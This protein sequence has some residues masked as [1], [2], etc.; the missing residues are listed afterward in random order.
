MS[1]FNTRYM[2]L[3]EFVRRHSRVAISLLLVFFVVASYGTMSLRLD[4]SFRPLFASGADIAA[5]T[6]EFEAVFGQSS[7]A[8]IIAVLQDNGDDRAKFLRASAHLTGQAQNISGITEVLSITSIQIPQWDRNSASLSFVSPIPEYLLEPGEGEELNYQYEELLDGTRFVNWLVSADGEKLL[9]AGRLDTPLDDLAGRRKIVTEFEA[10]LQR[11]APL[12]MGLYFSGVSVVELAYEKQVL[13]DQWIATVLTSLALMLLLYWTLGNMRLMIVCLAPVTLAIPAALGV[14]GWLGHPVTIINTVI[15][16]IML[17]LGVADAVHMLNAWL[18][19]RSEGRN[20]HAATRQ[21][22]ETTGKACFF[23]TVTTMGGFAALASAELE[24]VGD[25]G[26]SVAVGIFLAWLANQVLLP[27]ILRRFNAGG[28]LAAGLVNQCADNAVTGMLR[29]AVAHHR[30]MLLAGLLFTLGCALAIPALS[31]DQR[32]NEELPATHPI[33]QAQKI[34]EQ[35]FGGFLGPEISIRRVAGGSMIDTDAQ[36]RLTRFV[37]SLK[38]EPDTY[39]AWSIQDL[40]PLQL[41]ASE[42]AQVLSSLRSSPDTTHWARELISKRN[43]RLAVIVRIGDVGTERAAIFRDDIHRI[44]HEV[45]GDEFE[46]EVVGQW[47]LAQHGMRLLLGDM[48]A[49][50]ITAMIIVLP[51]MWLALREARLFFAAS[52]ANVLPL[53]LPLAFMAVTGISLR[54]GTAVVLALALGIVVDNTLHIIIRLRASLD[55]KGASGTNLP[56][57]LRGTGRAV[58]FTTL[59]LI[60]GFLSMLSNDLLAIRD[61]GLVAAVTIF[62]AMLADLLFLPAVFVALGG[63]EVRGTQLPARSIKKSA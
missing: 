52:I 59:A 12:D 23:T 47:W 32:F 29:F 5:T 48:L 40:L 7:G 20:L 34:L 51:L 50:L 25:F 36:T 39:H 3:Q 46:V 21:M 17:V 11:E 18:E 38:A 24:A 31:I 6:E 26:L 16:A 42:K 2:R 4:L 44:A 8:W 43:D 37:Q 9:L 62:G 10:V 49:S 30:Q 55:G 13:S 56:G 61:M 19:A 1:C 28:G 33:V 15:P 60:G 63:A 54:I 53:L 22:L 45:W 41:Q 57:A 35:E 27:W 14:M 58:V